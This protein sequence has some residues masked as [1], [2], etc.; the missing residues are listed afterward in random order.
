MLSD[1]RVCYHSTTMA[2]LTDRSKRSTSAPE[3][4]RKNQ[5]CS[6]V[7]ITLGVETLARLDELAR[8][9]NR[10]RTDLIREAL[11][12]TWLS[13]RD[14]HETP[15]AL[16]PQ[17]RRAPQSAGRTPEKDAE[18]STRLTAIQTRIASQLP[19][20]M[21]SEEIEREI[22]LASEE[23]RRERLRARRH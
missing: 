21:T 14:G 13:G 16:G 4:Q 8:A 22:T 20:G 11:D 3:R 7:T 19:K 6:R 5:E 15:S 23:A 17:S 12:K 9:L 18:W 10:T 1:N 2:T